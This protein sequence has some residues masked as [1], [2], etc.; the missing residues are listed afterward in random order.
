MGQYRFVEQISCQIGLQ[1]HHRETK[2]QVQ[3]LSTSQKPYATET[4]GSKLIYNISNHP[5]QRTAKEFDF[6]VVRVKIPLDK[7]SRQRTISKIDISVTQE[8]MRQDISYIVKITKPPKRNLSYAE[9]Q[10]LK[11]LRNNQ[12]IQATQQ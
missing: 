3:D 10:A 9:F 2:D 4:E 11:A 1:H 6:A 5:L 7:I 12:Q 8:S